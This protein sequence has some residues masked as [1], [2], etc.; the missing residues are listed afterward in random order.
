MK[1]KF[2]IISTLLFVNYINCQNTKGNL[3]VEYNITKGLIKSKEFLFVNQDNSLYTTDFIDFNNELNSLSKKNDNYIIQEKKLKINKMEYYSS[4]NKDSLFFV[5]IFPNGKKIIAMDKLPK[6][7]WEISNNQTKKIGGFTCVKASGNFRGSKIVAYY[8]IN[9]P[10][11]FGPFKFKG[12]PGLILEAYNEDSYGTKYTWAAK[13]IVFNHNL[14]KKIEFNKD[15]YH[16]K[17]VSYKSLIESFDIKMSNITKKLTSRSSRG[18]STKLIG[19]GRLGIE[20][21]YEWEL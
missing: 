5:S 11:P 21:I 8:A 19:K 2:I 17:I 16:Q 6:I 20:K 3:Y 4:L 12:L 1:I 9:I 10:L 18:S 13:K 7:K 15:N 14:K